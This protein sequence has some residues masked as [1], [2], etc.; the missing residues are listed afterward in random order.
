MVSG[1]QKE[2]IIADQTGILYY[3]TVDIKKMMKG[4]HMRKG[5][6]IFAFVLST[7]MMA[8]SINMPAATA[9]ARDNDEMVAAEAVTT[10]G[11]STRIVTLNSGDVDEDEEIDNRE[12]VVVTEGQNIDVEFVKDDTKKKYIFTPQK[13]GNYVLYTPNGMSIE[14]LSIALREEDGE[15]DYP[16]MV[17]SDFLGT[18]NIMTI[19]FK[20]QGGKS[21]F[22]EHTGEEEGTETFCIVKE[23]KPVSA[24]MTIERTF[25]YIEDE[26]EYYL[27]PY[28]KIN[29]TYADR[30]SQLLDPKSLIDGG[31][32]KYGNLFHL[33]ISK[34]EE[35][36]DAYGMTEVPFF[37]P[38]DNTKIAL[39][40]QNTEADQI[41]K[42]AESGI[43]FKPLDE[44]DTDILVPGKNTIQQYTWYKFNPS[45][46]AT[47]DNKSLEVA[48]QFYTYQNGEM[49]VLGFDLYTTF[50]SGT[51]YYMY[52]DNLYIA[53]LGDAEQREI[54]YPFKK[55]ETEDIIL[56]QDFEVEH[57]EVDEIYNM[58]DSEKRYIF[59]PEEDG[60]YVFFTPS[61][62]NE[63]DSFYLD[64]RDL[65][66]QEFVELAS[67]DV[68]AGMQQ[69]ICEL[70]KGRKYVIRYFKTYG[71]GDKNISEI[72]RVVKE[73][74]PISAKIVV[75]KSIPDCDSKPVYITPY[76][77]VIMTYEDNSTRENVINYNQTDHHKQMDA[78]GNI[79]YLYSYS[80]DQWWSDSDN[81]F[82][83]GAISTGDTKLAAGYQDSDTSDFVQLGECS[84][85]RVT[86]DMADVDSIPLGQSEVNGATW[87]QFVPSENGYIDIN[88]TGV[89]KSNPKIYTSENGKVSSEEVSSTML[90]QG[91]VYYLWFD[92][93][94]EDGKQIYNGVVDISFESMEERY[95][96][97]PA[98]EVDTSVTVDYGEKDSTYAEF[99][100]VPEEDGQYRFNID[101][102]PMVCA[103]V[104]DTRQEVLAY[105]QGTD[106]M[107]LTCNLEKNKYYRFYVEIQ[108]G[109]EQKGTCNISVEWDKYAGKEIKELKITGFDDIVYNID[110]SNLKECLYLFS[111]SLRYEIVYEGNLVRN[112]NVKDTPEIDG[113]QIDFSYDEEKGII[114]RIS[115]GDLISDEIVVPFGDLKNV[116]QVKVENNRADLDILDQGQYVYSFVAPVTGYYN[117]KT[118]TSGAGDI[119]FYGNIYSSKDLENAIKQNGE[120]LEAGETYYIGMY[121]Y[122]PECKITLV[123]TPEIKKVATCEGSGI[124]IVSKKKGDEY[125]SWY[126]LEEETVPALGHVNASAWEITKATAKAAGKKVLKCS[127]CGKVTKTETIPAIKTVTLATASYTYDGKAK[128][129]VV[130]VKDTNGKVIAA[131]NYTVTGGESRTDA[132]T[133]KITVTFKNDYQGSSTVNFTIRKAT[134][135]LKVT[136]NK[137]AITA[138]AAATLTVKGAKGKVSYTTSNNK[139][140][141]VSKKGKVTAKKAGKV[142]ITVKSAATANYNAATAKITI[143][144]K[145]KTTS[146]GKVT[147]PDKGQIKVTWKKNKTGDAYEIQYSTSKKFTKSTTKT[148]KVSKNS[149]TSATIK[150]LRAGKKYY[151][152]MR[153]TDKTGKLT[154]AWSAVKNITTKKK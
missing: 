66:T 45:Y 64:I 77:K 80:D 11:A 105:Q 40:Y 22:F 140:A 56:G 83:G 141:T 103:G 102:S 25:P 125:T 65:E 118:K 9:F 53:D 24:K 98:I 60:R 93:V 89:F 8:S 35:E 114:I 135:T 85:Q 41:E 111:R 150:K 37:S 147:S 112:V 13:D 97:L 132:G 138:G 38:D 46:M 42:F 109:T 23:N 68:I 28:L 69:V 26:M 124:K 29:V 78:Y 123:G 33:Y 106:G 59:T 67:S 76:V 2:I 49:E 120:I 1:K 108:S 31:I 73:N 44:A 72:Q 82:N 84:I 139:I 51:T 54:D 17:S 81:S 142:V 153:S 104:E 88:T 36:W 62:Y 3:D 6:R 131:S 30:T 7:V 122:D 127:R 149:T 99:V 117:L 113:V 61:R 96:K 52:S 101:G 55:I 20:L 18:K 90:V 63:T 100:F 130:V 154:S 110:K 129:P 12:T 14:D 133:Y 19:T 27:M 121:I 34:N 128:T 95:K 70:Q 47:L 75:D 5:K 136:A 79:Y 15:N 94:T 74:K 16:S 32:D 57:M 4:D 107:V 143:K 134:P 152:R 92:F 148:V 48:N 86:L 58:A 43:T 39:G 145:P 151:V 119:Q 91:K 144:V 115:S 146:I 10:D 137:T 116:S 50:Y 126:E 87:Y 71:K 21:Y